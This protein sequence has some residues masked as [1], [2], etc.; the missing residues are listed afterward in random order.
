MSL[1]LVWGAQQAR[2]SEA[3]RAEAAARHQ[4]RSQQRGAKFLWSEIPGVYLVFFTIPGV[5]LGIIQGVY[6]RLSS[7]IIFKGYL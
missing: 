2:P 6:R 5:Y 4:G 1:C 7:K 3:Q